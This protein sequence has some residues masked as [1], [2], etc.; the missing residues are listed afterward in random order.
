MWDM[1]KQ[2]LYDVFHMGLLMGNSGQNYHLDGI[3]IKLI[4]IFLRFYVN[5]THS[6]C[7]STEINS[8]GVLPAFSENIILIFRMLIVQYKLHYHQS[9]C[10]YLYLNMYLMLYCSVADKE[11]Y[12]GN[13]KK[14][15]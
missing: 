4:L 6:W 10:V 9:F 15:L 7:F 13:L 8:V 11:I 2:L 1:C 3:I 14:Q 5:E 12:C